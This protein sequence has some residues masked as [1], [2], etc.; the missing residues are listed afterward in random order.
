MLW[1]RTSLPVLSILYG[2]NQVVGSLLS[3]MLWL[4]ESLP[5]LYSL[6]L[7]LSL[8]ASF[9][10]LLSCLPISSGILES[11]NTFFFKDYLPILSMVIG[12]PIL[13][14]K[15]RHDY[16]KVTRPNI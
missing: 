15:G 14:L 11:I 7:S 4:V 2:N 1:C 10:A 13:F 16:L 9:A 8:I 6:I 3:S 12:M 5:S